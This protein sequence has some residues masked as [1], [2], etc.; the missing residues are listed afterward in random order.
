MDWMLFGIQWL[1][2]LAGITWFGASLTTNFIFVPAIGRLPIA[3]QRRVG[4]AYGQAANRLLRPTALL[5]ILLGILRGTVFG[6]L[7][8]L[9]DVIGTA[10]GQTWLVGMIVAI[11]TF[12]WAE[13]AIAPN[14]AKLNKIEQPLDA[15]G[16]PTPETQAIVARAK[17]NALL[18]TM[19]FVVV[20]TCMILMRFGY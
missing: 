8:S 13:A 6:Q 7:K 5:V 19:G 20:F 11:L 12:A 1:H 10:Y 14:I 15:E 17:R 18:E 2:V 4:A 16:N 9:D 3:E